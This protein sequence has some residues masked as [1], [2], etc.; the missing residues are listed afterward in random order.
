MQEKIKI[1][2]DGIWILQRLQ[3]YGYAVYAV[4]GCIRDTL[5]HKQ[6]HDWDFCT[7]A[8]PEQIQACFFDVPC[9]PIGIQ[10]GTISILRNGT[11]YEITTFRQE[12]TYQDHRHPDTVQFTTSIYADLQRRDFTINAM[13]YH[14]QSGLVDP[15]DG[16]AD[17][18][19]KILRCVGNPS[20]RFEE[21]ALRLLRAVRFAA[22]YG[23]KITSETAE[24]MRKTANLLQFVSAERILSECDRIVTAPHAAAILAEN[25]AVWFSIFSELQPMNG[26]L[27]HHP[28]HHQDVWQHSLTVLSHCDRSDSILCWAALLHDSGKPECFTQDENGIGHFYGH[29]ANSARKAEQVCIRLKM[30]KK[31]A[32]AI[33]EL[34]ASHEMQILPKRTYLL[35]LL[36]KHGVEQ[37]KRLISLRKADLQAQ[38]P[39]Y[40]KS[41][42]QKIQQMKVLLEEVLQE[43]ACFQLQDLCIRGKDLLELGI[44]QGKEIGTILKATLEQVINGT[45]PNERETLLQWIQQTR[46]SKSVT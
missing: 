11:I 26:Y 32:V 19:K 8:T 16:A 43:Q 37:T 14:P 28:R 4:G 31:R 29:P 36:R 45:L 23:L 25:T 13:A 3:S 27:Q 1:P 41:D 30:Q 15:F 24:A 38:V 12:S 2:E 20:K 7:N 39:D 35:R 33:V 44:P 21:D 10:H 42:L 22:V 9:F 17:L 6:P 5:L 18:Q 46:N 40:A 34:V